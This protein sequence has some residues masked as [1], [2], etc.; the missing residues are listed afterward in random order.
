MARNPALAGDIGA[1]PQDFLID[2]SPR[3]ARAKWAGEFRVWAG[4]LRR[5]ASPLGLLLLWQVTAELGLVS[6]QVLPPPTQIIAAFA[7][8]IENGELQRALPASIGRSLAGLSIGGGIG[9]LLGLF[10]GLWKKGEEIFDAPLQM[11]RTIP[12]ISAVP[13]FIIWFG[14]DESVKIIIILVATIFPVYL[15]TYSGVRSVDPKLI[16]AA[17][18]FGLSH[19]RIIR[20]VILPTAMPSILVGIRYAAGVSLLALVVSEQIN[21]RAGIGYILANAN[22]NQRS[23]IIIA[24][25]IV[26]AFLG[27]LTDII[28]RKVESSLLPWKPQH[29]VA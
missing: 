22:L 28:M 19:A 23:D 29:A 9:L 2:L 24:G 15:N 21:A 20:H 11:L 17:R 25:I 16:E 14:I 12:F 13:L 8:L 4:Y 5:L 7:E 3:V 1:Q 27:I 18:I 6:R 26:Y 10:A